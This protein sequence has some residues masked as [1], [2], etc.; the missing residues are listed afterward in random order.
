[1]ARVLIL[2]AHPALEKS[3]VH[4][5]LLKR[6]R[7]LSGITFRDLYQIYPDFDIDVKKEQALLLAH[8]IIIWQHPFYWYSCP[9]LLKQWEDLVLEHGWAYGTGGDKLAGKWIFNAIT[10]GGSKQMYSSSGRNRF[11]IRTLLAPFDQTAHLCHMKYM[12]PFLV[13]GTLRLSYENIEQSA[14]QYEKLLIALQNDRISMEE[15]SA[16]EYLN[17]LNIVSQPIQS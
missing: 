14:L 10:S 4:T 1:M 2:F 15:W 8:D 3:K 12:P 9:P 13:D 5:S 7:K 16:V 17:D 11:T 6:I